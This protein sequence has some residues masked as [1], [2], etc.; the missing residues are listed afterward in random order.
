MS[1][2]ADFSASQLLSLYRDRQL[3]PVEATKA[4]LEAIDTYLCPIRDFDGRI[5]ALQMRLYNPG[6]GGRYRWISSPEQTL[7]LLV[8]DSLENPLAVFHPVKP[9]GIA[10]VEGTGAKPLTL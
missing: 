4:A 9:K 5:V 1:Q 2:I 3:S 6:D 8:G 7:P 10:L